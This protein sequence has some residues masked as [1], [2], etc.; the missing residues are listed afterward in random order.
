[1][2][3]EP[4][5]VE[6]LAAIYGTLKWEGFDNV[7]VVVEAALEDLDAKRAVFR[8][9]EA[10]TRPATV[11]ATNT[12]SLPVERLQEGL[13]HPERV[14]GM[15]FFNPVHKMPLVE[16]A[17]ASASSELSLATLT[18]WAINLGKTPVL[19]RDSPGFVVNRILMPYL[20]EAVVLVSEGLDIE[21]VDRVMKRFGMPMGPLELL[22]QIGLDVA[23]H[24][25]QSMQPV[26]AGRFEPNAAFE[27]MRVQRLARPKERSRLLPPR[28][29][30]TEGQPTGAA[31]ASRR[32]F[33]P[34][35]RGAAGGRA[36]DGGTR[37]HGAAHGE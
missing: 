2:L 15:H 25:A 28:R 37:A 18:Q 6:R 24:V 31:T 1:M 17:R 16:V 20:N 30:E 19:V 21:Q 32:M 10:R 26:L 8:E 14:A 34:R 12:S 3:T 33:L 11:L 29:Q 22:D 5:S 35:N 7:A 13:A 9:L 23:A 4:E 27:K 36:R